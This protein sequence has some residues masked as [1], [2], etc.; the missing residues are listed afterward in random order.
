MQRRMPDIAEG[1]QLVRRRE[2]EGAGRVVLACVCI[3]N[4]FPR[5]WQP[6]VVFLPILAHWVTVF[7]LCDSVTLYDLVVVIVVV[8]APVFPSVSN[9]RGCLAQRVASA[10]TSRKAG[11]DRT[12]EVSRMNQH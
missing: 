9:M 5:P 12:R 6:C 4:S 11:I 2:V 7:S 3:G 8:T 1:S 10:D